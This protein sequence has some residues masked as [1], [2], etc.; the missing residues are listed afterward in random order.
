MSSL[1]PLPLMLSVQFVPLA[2]QIFCFVDLDSTNFHT[3]LDLHQWILVVELI[4]CQ[5]LS[6]YVEI[7][8]IILRKFI[9]NV[10]LINRFS[11]L[12][13]LDM[14][15]D[16]DLWHEPIWSP[17]WEKKLYSLSLVSPQVTIPLLHQNHGAESIDKQKWRKFKWWFPNTYWSFC[18]CVWEGGACV[19]P[20][21][22]P[23]VFPLLVQFGSYQHRYDVKVP[24]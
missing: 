11:I 6:W 4:H 9:S 5:I 13:K 10:I 17:H 14:L 21:Q 15:V 7:I 8:I 1:D 24:W 2:K 18:V 20:Q 19:H 16:F 22:L 12:I 23:R 3:F